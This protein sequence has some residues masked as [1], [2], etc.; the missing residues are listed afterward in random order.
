MRPVAFALR[1]FVMPVLRR[2]SVPLLVGLLVA[3]LLLL[4]AGVA[5]SPAA[6]PP[7]AQPTQPATGPGGAAV[8]YDGLLAQHF[9]PEPDGP[10][11]PTGYWLFEP[12]R[13]RAGV[14]L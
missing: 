4:R 13:P 2:L 7:P 11:E 3:P 6:T 5:A 10:G 8:A 1:R 9:G 14:A 12:T